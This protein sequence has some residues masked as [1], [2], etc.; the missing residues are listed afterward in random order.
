MATD[1]ELEAWR[2]DWQ[3]ASPP[4]LDLKAK[5]DRQTRMMRWAVV[6]DIIVTI[7]IGGGTLAL[8]LR[9]PRTQML[10]LTIGAWIFIGIAWAMSF[11]LR[12]GAWAPVT[13]TTTAFLDLSILRCRRRREAL[14]AQALL[15]V[16]ILTFDLVWIYLASAPDSRPGAMAFLMSPVILW[17]WVVTGALGALAVRHRRKLSRELAALT[18][19]RQQIG[20]PSEG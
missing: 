14:V 5:V 12:R 18:R 3:A 9:S 19:L 7:A 2:R 8:A 1:V 13:A 17:I 15:Y 20:E 10:V 6:A 4:I 11:L 16:M